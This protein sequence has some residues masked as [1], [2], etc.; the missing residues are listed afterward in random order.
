MHMY[1]L[2]ELTTIPIK[3]YYSF[4]GYPIFKDNRI[5]FISIDL[6]RA[7]LKLNELINKSK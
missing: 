3:K 1:K 7:K 2:G 6:E 5:I 4:T